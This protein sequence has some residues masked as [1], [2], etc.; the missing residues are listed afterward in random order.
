M[1]ERGEFYASLQE[2]VN[3]ESFV[4][5]TGG[6]SGIEL[7]KALE[8]KSFHLTSDAREVVHLINFNT[9]RRE[10]RVARI[11]V[12]DLKFETYP[13]IRHVLEHMEKLGL[14]LLPAE[15]G[16]YVRL[17]DDNQAKEDSYNIAMT[18]VATR[19]GSLVFDIVHLRESGVYRMWLGS[20]HSSNTTFP[21]SS[22]LVGVRQMS[23]EQ[24]IV[25]YKNFLQYMEE[26]DREDDEWL[27]ALDDP[28]KN[29]V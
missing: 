23:P 4:I 14:D 5:I 8:G 19:Y 24:K 20:S 29:N 17:Q 3:K 2:K 16:P 9:P 28:Y 7:E 12:E 11:K 1:I 6:S 13:Q 26:K 27:K 15:A 25:S 22:F 10:I 18:P 21:F